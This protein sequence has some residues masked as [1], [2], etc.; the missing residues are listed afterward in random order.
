MLQEVTKNTEYIELIDEPVKA[1]RKAIA[2]NCLNS[3]D[4]GGKETSTFSYNSAAHSS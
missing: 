3:L 2:K 1:K 4:L